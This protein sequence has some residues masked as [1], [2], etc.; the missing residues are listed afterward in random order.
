MQ[1]DRRRSW[2]GV[3]LLLVILG[4][5]CVVTAETR[6]EKITSMSSSKLLEQSGGCLALTYH[7]VR[8]DHI[9]T[10]IVEYLT[11]SDE[12]RH[13]SVYQ[14]EFEEHVRTLRAND[15]TFVTPAELREFRQTGRYP[16]KCVWISFD[17]V[18][19]S[20]Y[21][22]AFPILKKY[23]IPFTLFL[24]AGRV[25]DPDFEN[26]SLATWDQIQE[27]VDSGLA[28]VG[29]HTYDM[30]YLV[31]DKP[32]FFAPE[33]REAFLYDLVKS[34]ET[35]ERKLPGVKVVDFAYPFG[36]GRNELTPLIKQAGFLSAFVLEVETISEEDSLFWQSRVLVDHA[37]FQNTVE[38][39]LQSFGGD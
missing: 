18:D 2:K 14:S 24:I 7:R 16:K 6:K 22:N 13:Y 1:L 12:L 19:V 8:D 32:V 33:Q 27:M 36:E 35:I 31:N 37:T 15:V 29:S 26:F 10:K 25:G 39:W 28:T 30:H 9:V 4:L 11:N 5:V 3:G 20:V 23:Q 21:R 38:P 17:D 34:K